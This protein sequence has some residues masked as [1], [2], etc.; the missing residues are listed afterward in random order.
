MVSCVCK[1][2]I[3]VW[4][5]TQLFQVSEQTSLQIHIL[6]VIQHV[7]SVILICLWKIIQWA[8]WINSWHYC[9]CNDRL[10]KFILFF[11]I[12]YIHLK[13]TF[14]LSVD[15]SFGFNVRKKLILLHP[16]EI[17]LTFESKIECIVSVL[18]SSRLKF[19]NAF[20]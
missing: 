3:S 8:Y 10:G 5:I 11:T 16:G 6:F 4:F 17:D 1:D 18:K 7:D 13:K 14:R 9:R 2:R 20:H 12:L 15:I 19:F